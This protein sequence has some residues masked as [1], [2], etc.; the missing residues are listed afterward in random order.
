M[1]AKAAVRPVKALAMKNTPRAARNLTPN[2][3]WGSMPFLV[4]FGS[5]TMDQ[6]ERNYETNPLLDM[7]MTALL[8]AAV[9]LVPVNSLF[10]RRPVRHSQPVEQEGVYVRRL[11]DLL[12]QSH[13]A[14]ARVGTGS[15]QDRGR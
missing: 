5:G 12:G 9:C 4:E 3:G 2:S 7:N 6:P 8:R 15:Q 13:G 10:R 11:F 1:P 14:V